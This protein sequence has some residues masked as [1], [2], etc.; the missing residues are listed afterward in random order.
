MEGDCPVGD[1]KISWHLFQHIS[2]EQR[3]YALGNMKDLKE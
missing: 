2:V 3:L 1:L